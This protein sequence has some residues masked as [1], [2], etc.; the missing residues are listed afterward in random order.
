MRVNG[1][2]AG[3]SPFVEAFGWHLQLR[4]SH[5]SQ[6][7]SVNKGPVF[8]EISTAV[9]DPGAFG[10]CGGFTTRAKVMLPGNSG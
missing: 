8:G 4:S 6:A 10:L 3:S 1:D 5:R 7:N 9:D 2:L